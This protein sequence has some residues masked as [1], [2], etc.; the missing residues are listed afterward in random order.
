MGSE[1]GVGGWDY[2]RDMSSIPGEPRLVCFTYCITDNL[3]NIESIV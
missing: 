1:L 3:I 2:C